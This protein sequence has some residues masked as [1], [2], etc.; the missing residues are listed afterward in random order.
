MHYPILWY[1]SIFKQISVVIQWEREALLVTF[2][3]TGRSLLL[4]EQQ[5]ITTERC[6]YC[7]L[8]SKLGL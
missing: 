7:M 1:L 8:F 4:N 3:E 5:F 2:L 6:T